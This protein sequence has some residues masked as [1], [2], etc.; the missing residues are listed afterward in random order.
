[1]TLV[2]WLTTTLFLLAAGL[3]PAAA[4]A[5][6][7]DTWN[8]GELAYS[9]VYD[10]KLEVPSTCPCP[11]EVTIERKYVKHPPL[12]PPILPPKLQE[13]GNPYLEIAEKIVIPP[14]GGSVPARIRTPPAPNIPRTPAGVA[15]ND[16]TMVEGD[17]ILT[18]KV[19]PG[20]A[21]R[22]Q[23]C[24][25]R[26]VVTIHGHIHL[27]PGSGG[28]GR[29]PVNCDRYWE[30][31]RPPPDDA[32]EACIDRMRQLARVF[33][34]SELAPARETDPGPWSWLP[35]PAEIDGMSSRELLAMKTR[36]EAILQPSNAAV[37]T[38]PASASR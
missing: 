19:L 1:M 21:C 37:P 22:P 36:A 29:E 20:C 13:E 12:G 30:E 18:A 25:E 4:P 35:E 11:V 38:P 6:S 32:E 31:E 26:K 7:Q 17:L 34:E 27:D 23:D 14:G 33:L 3:G 15:L 16:L 24:D 8:W 2:R 5:L 28:S 9:R 10:T